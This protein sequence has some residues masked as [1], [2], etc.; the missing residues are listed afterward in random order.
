MPNKVSSNPNASVTALAGAV[1]ILLIWI[2]GV[3][4]L[5]VPAEVGSA[6]TT[7]S[8]AVILWIGPR[9]KPEPLPE[10]ATA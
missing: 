7:V 3:V 4:G 1:T 5:S 10:T 2:G 8:A 9:Q 6:F